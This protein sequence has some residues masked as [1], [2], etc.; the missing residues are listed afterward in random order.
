[1]SSRSKGARWIGRTRDKDAGVLAES[2]LTTYELDLVVW[3]RQAGA[4]SELNTLNLLRDGRENSFFQSIELVKAAPRADLAKADKNA[5]HRLEIER[6]IA[7]K[8][9][10]EATKRYSQRL[11]GLCL[12]CSRKVVST[13]CI[14]N[15]VVGTNQYR[16]ARKASL[17]AA[18]RELV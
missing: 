7:A 8:D 6:L 5:T 12:A 10:D 9:E 13:P 1:M 2:K 3:I 14:S 11:D 18:S 17:Q 16:Q 15:E 4:K